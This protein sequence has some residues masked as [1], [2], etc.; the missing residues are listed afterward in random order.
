MK[1]KVLAAAL[2]ATLTAMPSPNV[3]AVDIDMAASEAAGLASGD[4]EG[5]VTHPTTFASQATSIAHVFLSR[6]S[7]YGTAG[8][9]TFLSRFCTKGDSLALA[10]FNSTEPTGFTLILR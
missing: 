10:S 1:K 6:T 4:F 2:A 5:V 3:M 9:D 7:T 8:T